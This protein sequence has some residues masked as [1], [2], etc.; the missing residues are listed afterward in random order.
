MADVKEVRALGG[1]TVAATHHEHSTATAHPI[2]TR[3]KPRR[4]SDRPRK[5]PRMH[6]QRIPASPHILR[7]SARR[8]SSYSYRQRCNSISEVA[9]S[10]SAGASGYHIPPITQALIRNPRLPRTMRSKHSS[11]SQTTPLSSHHCQRQRSS[12]SLCLTSL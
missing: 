3:Q 6:C 2:P 9:V 1:Y 7:W 8:R 10:R 11:T 4:T 5:P 12:H